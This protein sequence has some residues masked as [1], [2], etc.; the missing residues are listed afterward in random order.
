MHF[1]V[2]NL[3]NK[4]ISYMGLSCA[5]LWDLRPGQIIYSHGNWIWPDF[6]FTDVETEV[7][8][9]CPMLLAIS[10]LDHYISSWNCWLNLCP[11]SKPLATLSQHNQFAAEENKEK[12][13]RLYLFPPFS[14]SFHPIWVLLTFYEWNFVLMLIIP[15]G[16]LHYKNFL[17]VVV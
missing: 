7:Q 17:K 11:T 13:T 4:A 10:S 14:S 6:V 3:P 15:F 9:N 16:E 8:S 2:S 12:S 1:F 5:Y